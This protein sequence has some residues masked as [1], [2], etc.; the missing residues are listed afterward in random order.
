MHVNVH[1]SD[2][3]FLNINIFYFLSFFPLS[4][5]YGFSLLCVWNKHVLVEELVA[6]GRASKDKRD[7]YYRK[8]KEEG[9][10]ARSAYKLLQIH[11]SFPLFNDIST[12]VVDLC[13]APGS[14][15]QVLAKLLRETQDKE[16]KILLERLHKVSIREKE[17]GAASLLSGHET[18]H[19]D[20]CSDC[21][22]DQKHFSLPASL[23][24]HHFQL[25][26]PPPIVAVD[27]QEMA[28][29]HGVIFLQGDIT[30][31]K[32]AAE[33]TSS[34]VKAA[35]ERQ[36]VL[37]DIEEKLSD[38]EN[39]REVSTRRI[40]E[41]AS[42]ADE[43]TPLAAQGSR[44]RL[45][46]SSSCSSSILASPLPSPSMI[47]VADI[48]VC[49][50][51]PDVTGLHELDEYLQHHLLLAALHIT[52][53]LLRPGGTFVT[54]MFRGPNTPFLLA[55]A[56]VFF[57]S[58][59]VLK[60]MS[61]R[62]ASMECFLLCEGFQLPLGYI[63][64]FPSSSSTPSSLQDTV[65]SI[66]EPVVDDSGSQEKS[67]SVHKNGEESSSRSLSSLKV[68]SEKRGGT[69]QRRR[70]DEGNSETIVQFDTLLTPPSKFSHFEDTL[71]QGSSHL[72]SS[73]STPHFSSFNSSHRGGMERNEFLYS[74]LACGDLSGYDA[75][76]CYEASSD[77]L[78]SLPPVHPP[79]QAPYLT[80]RDSAV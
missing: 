73:K 10:R 53:H 70:M 49:D 35:A 52:T 68:S 69:C 74:F 66:R 51:A 29:I 55:K 79:L 21:V 80:Q 60:P 19:T 50:G 54:K 38:A 44:K 17:I 63:P 41:R 77:Y 5:R 25:P 42:K 40:D 57:H 20:C 62:N 36:Q 43:L 2:I 13:A 24:H 27:L 3:A 39:K 61:S 31:A 45:S 28:P 18:Q 12:G 1:V 16:N 9:Y 7:I 26:P 4:C 37:R 11:E 14:W 78:S 15:S 72:L 30:S 65:I 33:I 67:I 59:R 8:A 46:S 48:V 56:E 6:M 34:L 71:L 47:S 64:T 22:S 23:S 75:D 76:M 58:V 32:T